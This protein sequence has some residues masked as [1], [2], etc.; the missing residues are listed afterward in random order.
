MKIKTLTASF[1]FLLSIVFGYLSAA[2][3]IHVKTPQEI[4]MDNFK[5]NSQAAEKLSPKEVEYETKNFEQY[6]KNIDNWNDSLEFANNERLVQ[7]EKEAES[8]EQIISKIVARL[9]HN[10]SGQ[11]S[12]AKEKASLL[13]EKSQTKTSKRRRMIDRELEQ[14]DVSL[15]FTKRKISH[16]EMAQDLLNETSKITVKAA[17]LPA[18]RIAASLDR[19]LDVLEK[20]LNSSKSNY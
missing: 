1:L 2:K 4:A 5:R 12:L 17:S 14:L 9:Q 6:R 15:T 7:I 10:L 18:Q 16:E 19:K 8:Q 3:W 20:K 11:R 13:K